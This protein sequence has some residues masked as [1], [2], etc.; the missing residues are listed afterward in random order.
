MSWNSEVEVTTHSPTVTETTDGT[1]DGRPYRRDTTD[2]NAPRQHQ[3]G[4]MKPYKHGPKPVIGL[5]GAIG[6]GKSTVARLFERRGGYLIDADGIGHEALR[7]AEIATALVARWGDTVL[8]TDGTIDRAKV[9]QIVF[10]N[11]KELSALE[12]IVFPYIARRCHEEIRRGIADPRY[13][14]I[15]LDAALLL[16][17]GWLDMVDR[18]VYVDAP[19]EVRLA[20]VSTRSGWTE[21]DLAAR[22][23]AQWPAERKLAH[24]HAVIMNTSAPDSLHAQ[25]DD[26]LRTWGWT[27]PESRLTGSSEILDC[28]PF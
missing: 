2:R 17:A 11:P 10:S 7:Q 13:H 3:D 26:L 24:A 20:R 5:I 6:A 1:T 16:E 14:F 15:V 8:R 21:A 18:V 22:E 28:P 27:G 25:V 12:A 23:S 4:P 9:G 19:R